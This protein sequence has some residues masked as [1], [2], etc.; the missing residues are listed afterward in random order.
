MKDNVTLVKKHF[1][2]TVS[3][4]VARAVKKN[5]D[6]VTKATKQ[7]F[8]KL[9]SQSAGRVQT[10]IAKELRLRGIQTQDDAGVVEA[11][12]PTNPLLTITQQ[13]LTDIA[14]QQAALSVSVYEAKAGIR[15]AS[16]RGKAARIRWPWS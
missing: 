16:S 13:L 4:E 3:A 11:H 2:E 8:V 7:G 10:F 9:L 5:M 1:E 12:A 15:L 14:M 6:D